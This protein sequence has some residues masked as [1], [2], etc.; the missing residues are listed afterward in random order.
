MAWQVAFCYSFGFGLQKNDQAAAV[1]LL[2]SGRSNK[3]LWLEIQERSKGWEL[4]FRNGEQTFQEGLFANLTRTGHVSLIDLAQHYRQTD[5]LDN[6]Q[7]SY[8]EEIQSIEMHL[9]IGRCLWLTLV[10]YCALVHEYAGELKEA[11]KLWKQ[12]LQASREYYG[13]SYSTLTCACSL[14]IT[15]N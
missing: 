8:A 14:A 10:H 12:C 4:T 11:E 5:S 3:E 2:K 9:P 6:I 13:N 1:W 7:A 15:Y